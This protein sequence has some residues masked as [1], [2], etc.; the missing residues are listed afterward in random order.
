MGVTQS[1]HCTAQGRCIYRKVRPKKTRVRHDYS[2]YCQAWQASFTRQGFALVPTLNARCVQ[3]LDHALELPG[4]LHGAPFPAPSPRHQGQ[5]NFMV[6]YPHV[7]SLHTGRKN[8]GEGR[9][10]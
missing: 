8:Q 3:S 2:W 4:G 10:L 7:F 6:E 1:T 5:G 9:K